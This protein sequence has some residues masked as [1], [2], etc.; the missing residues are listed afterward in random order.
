VLGLARSSARY[1]GKVDGYERRLV[2]RLRQLAGEH[3]R[4]GYCRIW[5]LLRRE[6]W[7]VNRKRVQ[8]LWRLEGLKVPPK[9]RKQRAPGHSENSCTSRRAEQINHVWSYDFVADQTDDGRALRFL[10]IVD[11]FTHECLS[12]EVERSMGAQEVIAALRKLVAGRAAPRLLR[13]D[14][15]GEFIAHA[16]QRWLSESAIE[17][18][19]I[20]PGSPWENAYVESFNS[21]LR[22][23]FLNREL[24]TSLAEANLLAARY[25]DE[26]NHHRPHSALGYQTPAEFAAVQLPSGSAPLRLREAERQPQPTL[27]SSGT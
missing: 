12:L 13:S 24:F 9:A 14:N 18:A 16:V 5:A 11:E 6:G 3:P 19:Y 2:A 15:G 10:A 25:R 1:H 23:E 7:K 8:R 26:Y 22:D 17:T 4:Y 21:R 27:I 20:A